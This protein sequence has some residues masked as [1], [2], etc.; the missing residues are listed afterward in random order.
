[1][2]I[3]ENQIYNVSYR[4]IH[5]ANSRNCTITTNLV[6]NAGTDAYYLTY[7][8]DNQV[9]DNTALNSTEYD[10][11]IA[12]FH[13]ERNY[14]GRNRLTGEGLGCIL[15]EGTDT[16]LLSISTPFVIGTT[17]N[18]TSGEIQGWNITLNTNYASTAIT[19]PMYVQQVVRIKIYGA[20]WVADA[21]KMTLQIEINGG[22]SDE[23][24][25]TENIAIA[26][27]LST[28]SNFALND[29]GYWTIT[30]SDDAD[31]GHLLGGDSLQIIIFHEAASGANVE[32]ALCARDVIF[33]FV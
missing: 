13:C 19:L 31:I 27:H 2:I 4:G 14:I 23:A 33:E 3:S 5:I 26:T 9:F 29:I 17:Y 7:A 28:T 20:F 11:E 18:P 8:D 15:D 6:E 24:F 30:A 12:T 16:M 22:T 21:D 25:N 10:I 1:M 32:T